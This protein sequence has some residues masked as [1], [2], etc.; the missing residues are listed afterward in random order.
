MSEPARTPAERERRELW[1]HAFPLLFLAFAAL[2]A[3]VVLG[4]EPPHVAG[5]RIPLWILPAAVAV[6]AG[7]GGGLLLAIGDFGFANAPNPPDPAPSDGYVRIRREDWER[8]QRLMALRSAPERPPA[9]SEEPEGSDAQSG[10]PRPDIVHSRSPAARAPG[11]LELPL[12]LAVPAG[13]AGRE[14]RAG[15]SARA[16][17]EPTVDQML[18]ELDALTRSASPLGAHGPARAS[19]APGPAPNGQPTHR[20]PGSSRPRAVVR[21]SRPTRPPAGPWDRT[22]PPPSIAASGGRAVQ[23]ADCAREVG[24]E[25]PYRCAR[26]TRAL[27]E[28]CHANGGAFGHRGYCTGCAILEP[29]AGRGDTGAFRGHEDPGL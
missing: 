26:C 14:P 4:L 5:V 10:R 11:A 13:P 28:A 6:V 12:S 9:W 20:W 16:A 18:G 8:L 17:A 22:A 7:C 19:P 29:M 1:R 23:C 3:A 2:L 24:D 25:P 27:C 15:A 21:E